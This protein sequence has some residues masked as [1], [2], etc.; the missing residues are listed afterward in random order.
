[1]RRFNPSEITFIKL[2]SEIKLDSDET[3]SKFLQDNYFTEE[4]NEALIIR[5][6]SKDVLFYMHPTI[7][8]DTNKRSEAL[9]NF[10]SIITLT[11][12]LLDQRYIANIPIRKQKGL[13]L[14]YEGFDNQVPLSGSKLKLNSLGDYLLTSKPDIIY[15]SNGEIRLKGLLWNELYSSISE[16]FMGIIYPSEGIKYLVKNK[17]RSEEDKRYY[18]QLKLTWIGL[19]LAAG[20]GLYSILTDQ[21]GSKETQNFRIE[22]ID[23]LKKIEQTNK[24]VGAQNVVTNDSLIKQQL[25]STG[26]LQLKLDRILESTSS[27]RQEISN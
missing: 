1:M 27:N 24:E 5:H 19:F 7:Y 22:L 13:D 15:Y 3:F 20:L 11:Q 18:T 8:D 14:M 23:V 25:E 2:I 12:Y 10:W 6:D 26:K 4:R 16:N 21:D 9:K 17:Y